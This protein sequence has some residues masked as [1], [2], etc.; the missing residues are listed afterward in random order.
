MNNNITLDDLLVNLG[1]KAVISQPWTEQDKKDSVA[2]CLV[3]V[4]L[5]LLLYNYHGSLND[6]WLQLLKNATV[7]LDD[8]ILL[9]K[10]NDFLSYP[11]RERMTDVLNELNKI[12]VKNGLPYSIQK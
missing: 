9:Q 1:I 3:V 12:K 10:V 7:W 5:G 11:S 6:V 4:E 2:L 8:I